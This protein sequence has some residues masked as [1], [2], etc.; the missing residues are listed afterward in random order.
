MTRMMSVSFR[1]LTVASPFAVVSPQA[2]SDSATLRVPRRN[3]PKKLAIPSLAP[4]ATQS[5]YISATLND[6]EIAK[7]GPADWRK[8]A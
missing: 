7:A 1:S 4:V 3:A 6:E 5:P 8:L 2:V